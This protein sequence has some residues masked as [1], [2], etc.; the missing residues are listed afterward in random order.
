MLGLYFISV[1]II[2]ESYKCDDTKIIYKYIPK[3]FADEQSEPVLVTQIFKKMFDLPSPWI[4]SIGTYD[5]KKQDLVNQ[6]FI[7]QA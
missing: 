2:K 5:R 1:S 6:Y 3:S 7:S 4:D